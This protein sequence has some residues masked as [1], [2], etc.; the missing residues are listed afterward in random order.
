MQIKQTA[1]VLINYAVSSVNQYT[2]NSKVVCSR[3][4]YPVIS[5]YRN[6]SLSVV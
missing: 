5:K 6:S 2:G 3:E 1:V 4:T